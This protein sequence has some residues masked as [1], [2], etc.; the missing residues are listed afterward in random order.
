M[1]G[2]VKMNYQK[3]SVCEGLVTFQDVRGV[4][5]PTWSCCQIISFE[6]YK[7]LNFYLLCCEEYQLETKPMRKLEP[8]IWILLV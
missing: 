1:S 6:F 4:S 2:F 7:T 8:G 3:T 5:A